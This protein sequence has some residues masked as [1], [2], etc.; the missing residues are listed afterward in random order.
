MKTGNEN[1]PKSGV[2]PGLKLARPEYQA[3]QNK[4]VGG[5]P[6]RG[7]VY[8]YDP[9]S[10]KPVKSDT[11][12]NFMDEGGPEQYLKNAYRARKPE[13]KKLSVPKKANSSVIDQISNKY[14]K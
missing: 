12:T 14:R 5:Q 11:I 13:A 8:E 7:L 10:P 3:V 6:Y 9:A 1:K 2:K 4:L